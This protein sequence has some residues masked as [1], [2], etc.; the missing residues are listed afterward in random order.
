MKYFKGIFQSE[1]TS[2]HT[3]VSDVIDTVHEYT[4][5]IPTLDD[6]FN[7][8]ELNTALMQIGTGV[9]LDGIPP[10]IAK[11][12]PANIKELI[13]R[14]MNRVFQ[15]PYPEEW[16]KQILHSIKKDGHTPGNPKL[17]GIAIAPFLCRI[18]DI[19]I[20]VRFCLWYTP[21]R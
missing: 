9:S 8:D 7:D 17:R 10:A 5:Y 21:N 18:Y 20:D 13:L 11:I 4:N 1:K 6:P 16:S 2:Q 19:M 12:L 15:G 3:I 14:L